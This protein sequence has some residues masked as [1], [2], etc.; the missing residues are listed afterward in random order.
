MLWCLVHQFSCSESLIFVTCSV[1][2]PFFNILCK[3]YLADKESCTEVF[4]KSSE[5]WNK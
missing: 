5:E 3:F 1:N 4:S 2:Y